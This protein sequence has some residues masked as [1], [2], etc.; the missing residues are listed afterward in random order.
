MN[1]SVPK[2]I[3]V[4]VSSDPDG[5]LGENF[6]KIPFLR[7]LRSAY[8]DAR[9]SWVPGTGAP[10]YENALAPMVEGLIDEFITD[11]V[12][13]KKARAILSSVRPLRGRAFD[14]IVDLQ[15]NLFWTLQLRR[16]AH[17]K[18]ISSTWGWVFSAAKPPKEQGRATRESIRLV[19][20][21]AAAAGRALPVPYDIPVPEKFREAAA[22]FL[23]PGPIYV[24][25]AP[26]AGN[27]VRGKLWPLD[28]YLALGRDQVTKGRKPVVFLGGSEKKWLD[29]IR[30][31][32]P[33]ALIPE[34]DDNAHLAVR[35]PA[36]TA[37][38]GRHLAAA[39]ANCSG[40]GH[41]LGTGGAPM[42][43]LYGPTNPEKYAPHGLRTVTIQ[44]RDF[45]GGKAIEAIPLEAVIAAVDAQIERSG[46]T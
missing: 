23:P 20:L 24:G 28:R 2:T 44:A 19:S 10:V 13:P 26:G 25:I 42:V 22:A 35:G 41:M 3:L 16:I 43:S 9:L 46:G 15:S 14:V 18:F 5:A 4:Y 17:K 36:L 33:E 8:P 40:T 34:F 6:I 27:Q 7:A 1:L 31:A 45:G 12:M 38:M 30:T 39:V 32:L 37:A 11:L 29:A 21:A